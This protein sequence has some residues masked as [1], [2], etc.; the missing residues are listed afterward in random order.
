MGKESAKSVS[1]S[2]FSNPVYIEADYSYKELVFLWLPL[3]G[4]EE[5]CKLQRYSLLWLLQDGRATTSS[6]RDMLL[7]KESFVAIHLCPRDL[8]CMD[9]HEES[10]SK[11]LRHVVWPD[12]AVLYESPHER[13][14]QK[15]LWDQRTY[16][17]L[18]FPS[19]GLKNTLHIGAN[20]IQDEVQFPARM[21]LCFL[22]FHTL[23]TFL[24]VD[25]LLDCPFLFPFLQKYLVLCPGK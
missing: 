3:G 6:Q 19:S 5:R 20:K 15:T 22:T 9:F 2:A 1:Y 18:F 4:K 16:I 14:F 7:L 12:P 8:C 17:L 24:R 11:E 25:F 10:M 13:A 21:I 23:Y